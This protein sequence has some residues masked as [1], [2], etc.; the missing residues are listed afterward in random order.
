MRALLHGLLWVQ[1][2][3][4]LV[5]DG[6]PMLEFPQTLGNLTSAPRDLAPGREP[7]IPTRLGL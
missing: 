6:V 5:S 2:S 3:K 7:A 4:R 1:V